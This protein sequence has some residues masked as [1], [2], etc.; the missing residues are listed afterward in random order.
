M[1]LTWRPEEDLVPTQPGSA[2][3]LRAVLRGVPIVLLLSA[4]LLL[5]L[6]LR[7][8]ERPIFGA[9]R[10]MTPWV[11]VA[12]CRGALRLLGLPLRIDGAP[13]RGAGAMLAN[14]SSWLDVLVLNALV[15]VVFIAKSQVARWPGI[16]WL[17]RAT[18]TVFVRREARGE[19]AQQAEALADRLRAGQRLVLFP[20]GTSTD[21][22]RVL[23][24]KPALLAGLLAPGLPEGV[25]VQPVTLAYQAPPGEDPRFYGWFGG[26]E[27]GP[28]A[29]AVLA[30]R[31]QGSVRLTLHAPIPVTGRDRKSL[32][33]E[34]EAAVRSAL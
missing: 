32:A 14:H 15:P 23:P 27:F 3:L 33:A 17:A 28:H 20:E 6:A 7:G 25:V 21:N 5:K 9:R 18:G 4:G 24:F 16:G 29:L 31:R 26:A 13:M 1:S 12:V 34:A 10:P 11:T 8:L 30:T 22:R 19:V 2:G